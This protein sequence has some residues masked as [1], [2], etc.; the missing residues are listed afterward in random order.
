MSGGIAY[1]LDEDG[2]FA[3]RCNMSMV[4]I[5]KLLPHDDQL[6][7]ALL[8]RGE[9]DEA[10]L[11]AVIAK[12]AEMSGSEKAKLILDKWEEYRDKFVK[13]FPHEYRRA[14]TEMAA[15]VKKNE[16]KEAA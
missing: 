1:V 10:Q 8:H 7:D 2:N 16:V 11:K 14:L 9:T 15:K 3:K 4:A 5:E 12:H 13:V 6:S